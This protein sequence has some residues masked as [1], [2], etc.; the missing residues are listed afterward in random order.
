MVA[1]G[2][3]ELPPLPFRP[4]EIV[5]TP[6]LRQPVLTKLC[7]TLNCFHGRLVA[8]EAVVN[9]EIHS[10]FKPI[11]PRDFSHATS[12]LLSLRPWC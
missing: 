8:P 3:L 2:S 11:I 7:S 12:W 5:N 4:V 9:L 10:A 6:P 1:T